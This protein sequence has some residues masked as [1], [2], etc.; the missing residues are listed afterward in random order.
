MSAVLRV[1]RL[2]LYLDI[3]TCALEETRR[4]AYED[5]RQSLPLYTRTTLSDSRSDN[6]SI[7]THLLLCA[8]LRSAIG[9]VGDWRIDYMGRRRGSAGRPTKEHEYQRTLSL[10]LYHC[11]DDT[12][13]A[14]SS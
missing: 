4:L 11:H 9:R 8:Q 1:P 6:V 7:N 5:I 3:Q 13:V 12:G 10:V 14:V 2:A